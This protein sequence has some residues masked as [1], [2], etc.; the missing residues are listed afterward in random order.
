MVISKA[1]KKKYRK[2]YNYYKKAL[3]EEANINKNDIYYNLGYI[4]L[5]F[6]YMRDYYIL[7]KDLSKD[8]LAAQRVTT[9]QLIIQEYYTYILH[10]QKYIMIDETEAEKEEDKKAA[11]A[12]INILHSIISKNLEDIIIPYE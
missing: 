12:H 2:L 1:F 10:L 9:Y 3:T 6:R 11:I 5:C 8:A 7:M 4:V